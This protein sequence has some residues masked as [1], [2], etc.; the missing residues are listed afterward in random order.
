MPLTRE[1]LDKFIKLRNESRYDS[2][3]QFQVDLD[4]AGISGI[5][6]LGKVKE[7]QEAVG[8]TMWTWDTPFG[9]L[10]EQDGVLSLER[11]N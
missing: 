11:N 8:L 4:A 9:K 7:V 3:F 2:N 5:S 10:V 1:Q 6:D